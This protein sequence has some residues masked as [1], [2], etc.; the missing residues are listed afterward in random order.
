MKRGQ[1]I[2]IS[3][4]ISPKDPLNCSRMNFTLIMTQ[5]YKNMGH[6]NPTASKIPKLSQAFETP[7]YNKAKKRQQ[8]NINNPRHLLANVALK[9]YI[10]SLTGTVGMGKAIC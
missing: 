1:R 8:Q 5:T 6:K 4:L 7:Q 2:N 3:T 9:L 10:Y